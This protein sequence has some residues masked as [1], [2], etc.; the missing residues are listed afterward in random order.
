[1][2]STLVLSSAERLDGGA[3]LP[4]R[5]SPNAS[6]NGPS[7]ADL[8]LRGQA[9]HGAPVPAA[10]ASPPHG[11]APP[12]Q[13]VTSEPS[14]AAPAEPPA[15]APDQAAKGPAR[16]ALRA[17][18]KAAASQSATRA[19]SPQAS[20]GTAANEALH[21]LKAADD[22]GGLPPGTMPL[23]D[24][25]AWMASLAPPEPLP[26]LYGR[27]AAPDLVAAA[28][29]R[30]AGE[31]DA[32][33][34]ATDASAVVAADGAALPLSAE[35]S[36]RPRST[37]GAAMPGL[38]DEVAALKPTDAAAALVSTDRGATLRLADGAATP[39]TAP[40]TA[41]LKPTPS[42]AL[43]SSAEVATA[44]APT[45]RGAL[46]DPAGGTA[47]SRP[48]SAAVNGLP[49]QRSAADHDDARRSDS[50]TAMLAVRTSAQGLD[51]AALASAERRPAA[52]DL[53][54]VRDF[55][56]GLAG[57]A[58]AAVAR[59]GDPG[60]PASI[61]LPAPL[62]SAEFA[63]LL[64]AQVSLLARDG[65]QQ[66]ELHLN[67]AEMG[68]I[69]VRIRIDDT[70]ARVDFHA[71]AAATREVIE[72]GLPELASALREQGLTL[73]GGGVFQQPPDARGQA[74]RDPAG[75]AGES[76]RLASM[77]GEAPVRT[78]TIPLPQGA[79][80]VYA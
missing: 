40:G 72:R 37:D 20:A 3:P 33:A 64:G 78:I 16:P 22:S 71:G 41:A 67:P 8:L 30:P 61:A 79:L 24:L 77:Q 12:S 69:N 57:G 45:D 36:S 42:A 51:P 55:V 1:M 18:E 26:A 25:Q 68:P 17:R 44:L 6:Q 43:F 59:G 39:R 63:Q 27:A 53:P 15:Q 48:A 47:A 13:D 11:D 75:A 65:V 21:E 32:P 52:R 2:A 49:A 54:A 46:L 23:A 74:T 56:Q 76:R 62:H 7:F 28:G 10:E 73:A 34:L 35:G 58:T 4:G 80:D 38:A 70:H 31:A 66:A 29:P 19:S 60:T 50:A 14:D 5:S 9:A